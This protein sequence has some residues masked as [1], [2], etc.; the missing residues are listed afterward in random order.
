MAGGPTRPDTY[1]VSVEIAHP[2]SGN[3]IPYAVWDKFSGGEIDSEEAV[4]HPGGMAPPVSLGGRKNVGNV[5][6][7]RLYRL[8]RDH[9]VVQQLIDSVGRSSMTVTKQPL[10]VEGKIYG[11]PIVYKGTLK[12]CTPPEVDSEG[13]GAGMIEL[14]MTV[15]GYPSS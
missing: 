5:T 14:E 10:T 12:R 4:Y 9:D 1:S 13:S 6:V 15:E 2:V 3:M 8:G 7:S 11:K